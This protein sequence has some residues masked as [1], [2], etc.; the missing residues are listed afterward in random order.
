MA[1]GDIVFIKSRAGFTSLDDICHEDGADVGGN[2]AN[3]LGS[4]V[5]SLTA[6]V[7]GTYAA[8]AYVGYNAG[9]ARTISLSL[10]DTAI[11]SIR[12]NGGEPKLISMG[13]DQYFN[14]ASLLQANQR[15]LDYGEFVFGVGDERTY[16]GTKVGMQL[17]SYNGI[18]ILPDNDIPKSVAAASDEVLGSN[19]YVLDLDDIELAVAIPTMYV[20]NRDFFAAGATVVRGLLYT[21]GELR[22]QN[23][24][25]NSKISDLAA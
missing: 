7:A 3:T 18:P 1:D 25:R 12:Q 22:C 10:V 2:T 19:V 8:G 17:A 23:I 14:F 20:E 11:K 9:V 15:Y 6:R 21:M 16:P 5:Y 4:D 24:W 13:H